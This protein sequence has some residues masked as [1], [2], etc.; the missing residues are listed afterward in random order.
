MYLVE[1]FFYAALDLKSFDWAKLFLLMIGKRYTQSVKSMR[2]QAML[3]ETL[4]EHEKAKAIYAELI[5]I[6]P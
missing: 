4:Q 1:E 2:M 6:N 5:Q 3:F